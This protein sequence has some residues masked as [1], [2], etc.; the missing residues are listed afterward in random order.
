MR[1]KTPPQVPPLVGPALPLSLHARIP[2]ALPTPTLPAPTL[3]AA[4]L[5]RRAAPP[6]ERRRPGL[7]LP[8][9][10]GCGQQPSPAS[11]SP[12]AVA[13]ASRLAR[14]LGNMDRGVACTAAPA[15]LL[16]GWFSRAVAG[17]HAAACAWAPLEA[18]RAL[19]GCEGL[20][21]AL[22]AA[23]PLSTPSASLGTAGARRT[24]ARLLP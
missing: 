23:L 11:V 10:G 20:P 3:K 24:A 8:A 9:A 4:T 1:A 7:S 22:P 5:M 15:P 13:A 21:R 2:F 18:E 16:S 19:L 6:R 17:C 12:S 14:V